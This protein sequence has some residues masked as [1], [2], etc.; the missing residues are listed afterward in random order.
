MDGT[1]G[2]IQERRVFFLYFF[3]LNFLF[4]FYDPQKENREIIGKQ[5]AYETGKTLIKP[6]D[7]I[8][9]IAGQ[10]TV[11]KE[12][13][14]QFKEINIIPDIYLCSVSGGGLIAGS[15]YYLKSN[16]IN[17]NNLQK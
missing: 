4:V 11:G 5:I 2:S 14:E 12:I 13:T 16:L 6:Y 9:I 15:S 10:G 1:L 8:E 7:D 3:H 17:H